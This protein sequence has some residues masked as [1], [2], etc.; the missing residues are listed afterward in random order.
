VLTE[1]ERDRLLAQL[2]ATLAGA[3]IL[4]DLRARAAVLTVE[5]VEDSLQRSRRRWATGAHHH[6]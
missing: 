1:A 2:F 5:D 6:E 3:Q 4:A